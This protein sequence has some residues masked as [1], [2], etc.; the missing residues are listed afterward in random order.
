MSA[1]VKEDSATASLGHRPKQT[2]LSPRAFKEIPDDREAQALGQYLRDMLREQDI[3]P[4]RMT[5]TG[6][7]KNTITTTMDG[8]YKGWPSVEKWLEVFTD[9]RVGGTYT[10]Q[11]YDRIRELH[12][13]GR[14]KHEQNLKKTVQPRKK[15]RP[16]RAEQVTPAAV[17]S[18]AVAPVALGR[19]AASSGSLHAQLPRREPGMRINVAEG[20]FLDDE[21][22]RARVRALR[23]ETQRR[24]EEARQRR[25]EEWAKI[26]PG[27]R[28][29]LGRATVDQPTPQLTLSEAIMHAHA[30]WR[31]TLYSSRSREDRIL[32]RLRKQA[33]E[34]L[35]AAEELRAAQAEQA[36]ELHSSGN[37][38]TAPIDRTTRSRR[39]LP[40]LSAITRILLAPATWWSV[41]G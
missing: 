33:Q 2:K 26:P 17:P 21:E 41:K 29:F 28:R 23:E 18:P 15:P 22:A 35:E 14:R 27:H 36:E 30:Q 10:Q 4:S 16:R 9:K 38:G 8:R 6:V 34:R 19:F 25:A 31:G 20:V 39:A 7:A 37:A 5:R 40:V 12:E 1:P 13:E 32:A 11:Q 3:L 24:A